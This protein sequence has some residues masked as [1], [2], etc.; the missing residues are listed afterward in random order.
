MGLRSTEDF[1]HEIAEGTITNLVA[2]YP[3]LGAGAGVLAACVGTGVPAT[4]LYI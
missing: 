4:H 3:L 2:L 1:K